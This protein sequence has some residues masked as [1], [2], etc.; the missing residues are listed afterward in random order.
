M[1]V[2]ILKVL[3]WTDKQKQMQKSKEGYWCC[4]F[5]SDFVN[6]FLAIDFISL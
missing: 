5:S 4:W 6:K 2:I 3:S 1:E